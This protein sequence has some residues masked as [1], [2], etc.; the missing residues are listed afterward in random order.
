MLCYG[1]KVNANFPL[2]PLH[3]N[4]KVIALFNDFQSAWVILNV[5]VIK[6]VKR[7]EK[8]MTFSRR[9]VKNDS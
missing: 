7:K 5:Q 6:T 8:I 9:N 4:N 1:L 2:L 3:V